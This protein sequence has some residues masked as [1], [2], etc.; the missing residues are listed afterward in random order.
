MRQQA[1][2]GRRP[3]ALATAVIARSSHR[4][5]RHV[6]TGL[7][8]VRTLVLLVAAVDLRGGCIRLGVNLRHYCTLDIPVRAG[9]VSVRRIVAS[10]S[11]PRNVGNPLRIVV[12]VDRL[13]QLLR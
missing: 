9:H 8:G 4:P 12:T 3:A 13:H 6:D 7:D 10:H 11:W 1:C 2:L 5:G